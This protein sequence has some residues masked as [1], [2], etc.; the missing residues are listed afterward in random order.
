MAV[1]VKMDGPPQTFTG[2]PRF[3]PGLNQILP[4]AA[5]LTTSSSTAIDWMYG[6]RGIRLPH[7]RRQHTLLARGGVDLVLDEIRAQKRRA[8]AGIKNSVDGCERDMVNVTRARCGRRRLK[9][10]LEW[11]RQ[12]TGSASG[13]QRCKVSAGKVGGRA[14]S[15]YRGSLASMGA[16]VAGTDVRMINCG[17]RIMGGP[18]AR[19]EH[20][21]GAGVS[22]GGHSAV[23]E[24]GHRVWKWVGGGQECFVPCGEPETARSRWRVGSG[25]LYGDGFRTRDFEKQQIW[26]IEAVSGVIRERTGVGVLV[27]R[28]VALKQEPSRGEQGALRARRT[29]SAKRLYGRACRKWWARSVLFGSRRRALSGNRK[30]RAKDARGCHEVRRGATWQRSTVSVRHGAQ[31][32]RDR[33]WTWTDWER[34]V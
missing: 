20:R 15:T 30:R 4:R 34:D 17:R 32:Q 1:R 33:Q 8:R 13:S 21:W 7:F 24:G 19:R 2:G 26:S 12:A 18:R 9:S 29:V 16:F 22:R 25:R 6:G 14:S 27:R 28:T 10:E 23:R 31:R 3:E 5:S 11:W